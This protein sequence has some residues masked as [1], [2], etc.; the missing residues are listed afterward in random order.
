MGVRGSCRA[1]V[2]IWDAATLN[3]LVALLNNRETDAIGLNPAAM[4]AIWTLGGL[5]DNG[6]PDAQKAIGSCLSKKAFHIPQV[7]SARLQSSIAV[8]TK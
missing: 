4:H 6:N 8:P 5:R 3:A 7:L 1:K 2:A